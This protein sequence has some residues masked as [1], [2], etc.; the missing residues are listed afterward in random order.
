MIC[1]RRLKSIEDIISEHP[2]RD[3]SGFEE[4]VNIISNTGKEW[5]IN[6]EMLKMFG[7]GK[8]YK[9]VCLKE[10][11]ENYTHVCLD[12]DYYYD[13][14]WFLDET[15]KTLKDPSLIEPTTVKIKDLEIPE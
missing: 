7:N 2:D 4:G 8:Q 12:D 11:D 13:E 1:Q 10:D 3:R 15:N 14:S 6:N 9:F 5:Y